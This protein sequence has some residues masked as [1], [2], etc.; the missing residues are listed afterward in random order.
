MSNLKHILPGEPI[1]RGSL[2]HERRYRVALIHTDSLKNNG[3][4]LDIGCGNASQTEYFARHFTQTVGV[5]L[6]FHRLP[7]F[8]K[9]LIDSGISNIELMGANSQ[10]LPF[11]H[12]VFDYVTCFEVLEHVV[13]Q[14]R[15]LAEIWRV[16]KPNGIIILSVP[17]RWW[18]FETHGADLPVLPWNRVP[19]FS[20][21]P[22][23]IHD[24]WARARNYTRKETEKIVKETGF[25]QIQ[26]KL[27]TAPMDVVK[28]E[29]LQKLLRAAI[30]INDITSIT[31]LASNIFICAKKCT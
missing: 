23:S 1:P 27:L 31:F 3:Y 6:Q 20:W 11:N 2:F 5:D 14:Q 18:I 13:E 30:F 16:L 10:N 15:T 19:L 4:L 7:G 22:K 29:K 21:L 12:D 17:H 28:N 26:I 8:Q 24:R 25:S 9:E